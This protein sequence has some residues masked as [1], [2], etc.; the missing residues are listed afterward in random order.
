MIEHP[1]DTN[2]NS[3]ETDEKQAVKDG[4]IDYDDDQWSPANTAGKK[5]YTRD[6]LLKLKEAVAIP[7]LKLPEGV[8]N[9]LM[10]NNKDCLT[11]TL[12]QTIPPLGMRMPFDAINSVAP[13]FL[14]TQL[15]GRNPYPN[16]RPSQQGMK[17]QVC[18]KFREIE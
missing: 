14:A 5:Y 17:Q 10:K 15:S 13:K 2:N 8:A 11:N 7:P 9:T 16:K 3:T 18:R 12:N 1:Q 6:Q 4:P